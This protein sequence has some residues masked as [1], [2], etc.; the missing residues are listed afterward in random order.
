MII[1]EVLFESPELTLFDFYVGLD[2]ER[3]LQ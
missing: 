3:S 1:E 2:E